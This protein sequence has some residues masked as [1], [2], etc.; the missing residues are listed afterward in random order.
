M[1]KLADEYQIESVIEMCLNLIETTEITKDNIFTMFK[2]SK[3]CKK[4]RVHKKCFKALRHLTVSELKNADVDENLDQDEL[5]SV[6]SSKASRLEKCLKRVLPEFVG[7]LDCVLYFWFEKGKDNVS[8]CIPNRCPAHYLH[9]KASKNATIK[10]RVKC[11]AC[12]MMF[13]E[14]K[15]KLLT[16][17]GE[18]DRY[19]YMYTDS[20]AHF[21]DIITSL[22]E[23][24]D[25]LHGDV[26]GS[27]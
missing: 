18:N 26:T 3:L 1:Y 11:G 16:D 21:D 25:L 6:L 9:G 27:P 12:R 20:G 4:D 17:M 2:V 23:M 8:A 14:M 13:L 19:T 15:F 10:D 24:Y 7:L 5:L 22:K